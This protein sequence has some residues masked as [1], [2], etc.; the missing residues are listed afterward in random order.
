MSCNLFSIFIFTLILFYFLRVYCR[1]WMYCLSNWIIYITRSK[2]ICWANFTCRLGVKVECIFRTNGEN[3]SSF[4]LHFCNSWYLSTF[5]FMVYSSMSRFNNKTLVIIQISCNR[6]FFINTRIV[7][8]LNV[9]GNNDLSR[10]TC[11]LYVLLKV[12]RLFHSNAPEM[13]IIDRS[14]CIYLY[15]AVFKFRRVA[16]GATFNVGIHME[17][18][19]RVGYGLFNPPWISRTKLLVKTS[20]KVVLIAHPFLFLQ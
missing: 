3:E 17:P 20:L 11:D 2:K 16:Q 1:F 10:I 14:A 13:M 12:I 19:N 7:T 9:T 5:A 6:F 15:T 18:S 8:F 4:G